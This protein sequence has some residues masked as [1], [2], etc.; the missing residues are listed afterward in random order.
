MPG[1]RIEGDEG[2]LRITMARP[3]RRNAFDAALIAEL[4]D[5]FGDVGDAR[6]V[7]LAGDGLSFSAGAGGERMRSSIQLSYDED[8]AHPPPLRGMLGALDGCPAPAV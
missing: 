7:V 6:A 2:V 3:D 8:A 1:L 5:A 4:T